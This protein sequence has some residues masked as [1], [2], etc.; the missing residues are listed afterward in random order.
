MSFFYFLNS[1]GSLMF[2]CFGIP[3]GRL[4][5]QFLKLSPVIERPLH[6]RYQFVRYIDGESF[7]LHSHIKEIAGVLFPLQAGFAVLTDTGA[8]TQTQRAQS[9]RP[10]IG[11][12]IPEPLLNIYGRFV[13]AWH[14]V[15][16]PHSLH[17]VKHNPLSVFTTICCE[18]RDRN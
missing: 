8:P 9:D 5:E 3:H 2:Q 16:M 1:G 11:C 4:T 12:M 15:C 14:V 13:F 18:F 17:I 10:E 6:I 7:P